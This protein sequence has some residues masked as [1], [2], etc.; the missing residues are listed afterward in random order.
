MSYEEN[1][2]AAAA[3]VAAAEIDTTRGRGG[4]C[5]LGAAASDYIVLK[6]MYTT[7]K[8]YVYNYV[9]TVITLVQKRDVVLHQHE[10]LLNCCK[11]LLQKDLFLA[12]RNL[13]S[14]TVCNIYQYYYY[15]YYL[16]EDQNKEPADLIDRSRI[17]CRQRNRKSLAGYSTI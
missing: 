9:R 16:R 12:E 7:I 2:A 8:T 10:I 1:A 13:A 14:H 11:V 6:L 17:Y 4:G 3:A 5:S 15:T